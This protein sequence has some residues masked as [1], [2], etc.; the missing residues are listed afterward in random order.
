MEVEELATPTWLLIAT[1]VEV[2][3]QGRGERERDRNAGAT[4]DTLVGESQGWRP[5]E[6]TRELGSSIHQQL[7]SNGADSTA[8]IS[9]VYH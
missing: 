2:V 9:S 3:T 1:S 4:P 8:K 6:L 7:W 5:K